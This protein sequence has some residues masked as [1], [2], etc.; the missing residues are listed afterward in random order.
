VSLL[1][2][3]GEEAQGLAKN[4]VSVPKLLE[5]DF[6][7][8]DFLEIAGFEVEDELALIAGEDFGVGNRGEV[9]DDESLP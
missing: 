4:E 8:E 1:F 2:P 3:G 5:G 7:E 9:P 6:G